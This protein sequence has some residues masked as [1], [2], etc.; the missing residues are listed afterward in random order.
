LPAGACSLIHENPFQGLRQEKVGQK[1]W[2]HVSPA[3]YR[4]LIEAA[5]SLQWRGM[6][7]LGYYC[8]LRLGEV[9]NL[10]WCDVDFEQHRV[11]VVRKN[12]SECRA[13]WVPKDK[14]MRIV[15]LPDQAVPDTLQNHEGADPVS[16]CCDRSCSKREGAESP[17]PCDLCW[18]LKRSVKAG[19][20]CL[21][22]DN[23]RDDGYQHGNLS[24]CVWVLGRRDPLGTRATLSV[25]AAGSSVSG[26]RARESAQ[27]R[28]NGASPG[29]MFHF[30]R[31][32]LLREKTEISGQARKSR[33][34]TWQAGQDRVH[35]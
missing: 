14:D 23:A 9:L 4:K 20:L 24:P 16:P 8:G 19:D 26:V 31:S 13:A 17:P 2:H 10:T 18:R 6:I 34:P 7:S 33:K 28:G 25:C 5:P 12:A 22:R 21:N 3:E 30:A 29:G 35:S 15:P 27:R 1:A 32:F 11:R